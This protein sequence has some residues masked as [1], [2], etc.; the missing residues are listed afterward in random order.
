MA[1]NL[2]EGA[3]ESEA[4]RSVTLDSQARFVSCH[5]T[6]SSRVTLDDPRRPE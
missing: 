5:L 2:L 6:G 1:M 4:S 3:L